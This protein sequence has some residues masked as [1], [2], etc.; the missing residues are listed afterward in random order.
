M[1]KILALLIAMSML[2]PTVFTL[3]SCGDDYYEYDPEEDE[4]GNDGPQ[5]PDGEKDTTP[6]LVVPPYKDYGRP[7]VSFEDMVYSRPDIEALSSAFLALSQKIEDSQIAYDA[8]LAEIEAL[9]E[10]Y[11]HVV[12]MYSYANIRNNKDNSDSYWNGEYKFISTS[13]PSFA[14]AVEEL[15]VSCARSSNA[16]RY[17]EDYFGDGLIEQYRDGGKYTA[18]VVA[19]MEKEAELETDY[20][21]FSTENVEITIDGETNTVDYFLSQ[22][23]DRYGEDT[24]RYEIKHSY[25][26]ALYNNRVSEL[27]VPMLVELIKVRR[28]IADALGYDS[29]ATLAYKSLY[30][31]YSEDDALEF[32]KGIADNIVPLYQKLSNDIFRQQTIPAGV[33]GIHRNTVLNNLYSLYGG[34]NGELS[35]AFSFMLSQKLFD[36]AP[37]AANRYSGAFS[38]Y[39]DKYD[40]PYV[41]VTTR[42][43]VFDY[44]TVS[45]EFGHFTDSYLN[46]GDKTSLDMSEVYSQG[47]ELLTALSLGETLGEQIQSYLVDTEID[48][49]LYNMISQGFYA[50]FECEAY[51]LSYDEITE[52]RLVG[53][54][55]SVAERFSLDPTAIGG[56]TA[57]TTTHIMLYPFYVQSYAVSAA[58]ALEIYFLEEGKAGDGLAAYMALLKREGDNPDFNT[59]LNNAGIASPFENGYL[60]RLVN[61]VHRHFYGTDYYKSASN[62]N[63]T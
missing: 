35:D 60:R 45:H 14:K 23:K 31:D 63:A 26:L 33:N 46:Y 1:K 41:F 37:E 9:E 48:E 55:E 7:A 38:I 50:L 21:S 17:E 61:K 2:L 28:Q 58:S 20:S 16:E 52:A 12:T 53:I 39:L 42:G 59:A 44:M 54:V 25:C 47:L 5:R 8:S 11:E 40:S 15:F 56:L 49:M 22:Y 24:D 19:L 27:S 29:Y 57:V 34:M 6:V 3:S 10:P 4:G 32:V 62:L 43:N 51:S 13:Y 18:E 36:I 30:H